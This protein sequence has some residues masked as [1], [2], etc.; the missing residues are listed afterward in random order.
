[1]II[2]AKASALTPT[3]SWIWLKVWTLTTKFQTCLMHFTL[4]T[5]LSLSL[6]IILKVTRARKVQHRCH[7]IIVI[8]RKWISFRSSRLKPLI[9]KL[10][11]MCWRQRSRLTR[12][13]WVRIMRMVITILNKCRIIHWWFPRRLMMKE[14]KFPTKKFK[15]ELLKAGGYIF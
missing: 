3:T 11:L 2:K 8:Q 4:M 9:Q 13:M 14:F 15:L 6:Q 10:S 12:L 1:M 7:L 5:S